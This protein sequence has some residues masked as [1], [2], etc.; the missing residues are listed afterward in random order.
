MVI[1]TRR[2]RV[3]HRR[4]QRLEVRGRI[5]GAGVPGRVGERLHSQHPMPIGGQVVPTQAGQHP[6][7]HRRSKVVPQ[8]ARGQHTEPLIVRDMP[9]P[10]VLLLPRPPQARTLAPGSMALADHPKTVNLRED[11]VLEPL[12]SWIG[13][14]FGR[15]NVDQT[16]AAL[17]ASQRQTPA[18]SKDRDAMKKRLA[19]AEARLR[20]YQDAIAAGVDPAALVEAIN[21]AQAQRAAAQAELEGAPPPTD[22]TD[23][24]VY[25]MIDSLGDVGAALTDARPESA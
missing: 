5:T 12:N 11:D 1:S 6:G 24:E 10:R 25:A 3:P 14:L 16:V 8:L 23:A 20:R 19:D 21:Q 13:H 9:Q 2:T 22:L 17:I 7:E 4:P 15:E 18:G